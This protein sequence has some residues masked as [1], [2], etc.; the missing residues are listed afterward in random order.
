MYLVGLH[1]YDYNDKYTTQR[2][3]TNTKTGELVNIKYYD[4]DENGTMYSD[5]THSEMYNVGI[6]Y[7]TC[8]RDNRD[9]VENTFFAFSEEQ[10]DW[11]NQNLVVE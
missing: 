9:G 8:L 7:Q 4:G 5:R 10:I 11:L 2:L 1:Y 3:I 6:E